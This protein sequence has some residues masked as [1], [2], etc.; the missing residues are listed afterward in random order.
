MHHGTGIVHRLQD[1]R[2]IR[3]LNGPLL[4]LAW[5]AVLDGDLSWDPPELRDRGDVKCGLIGGRVMETQD[6]GTDP[7]WT[8]TRT[9]LA[10]HRRDTYANAFEEGFGLDDLVSFFRSLRLSS[11]Q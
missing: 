1:Y 4:S 10:I 2:G 3:W 5:A 6:P 11:P 7:R 9:Q 8:E